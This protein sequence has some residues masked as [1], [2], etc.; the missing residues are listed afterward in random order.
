MGPTVYNRATC[1]PSNAFIGY[2]GKI[3]LVGTFAEL[4][5]IGKSA[6]SL[7]GSVFYG[8][9]DRPSDGGLGRVVMKIK[10]QFPRLRC[11]GEGNW[12]GGIG[13]IY[14]VKPC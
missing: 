11:V 14:A 2:T 10:A 3:E 7:G 1:I 9:S 4:D 13:A 12:G 8:T 6:F 5:F